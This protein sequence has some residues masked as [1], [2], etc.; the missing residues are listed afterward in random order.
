V[1]VSENPVRI[2]IARPYD[3]AALLELKRRLDEEM[4]VILPAPS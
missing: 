4:A 1:S 3:A 2:R